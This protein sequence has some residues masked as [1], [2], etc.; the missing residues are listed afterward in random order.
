MAE[1]GVDVKREMELMSWMFQEKFRTDPYR[2]VIA[3]FPWGQKGTPL[4]R[5]EGPR[6]WQCDELKRLA[7]YIKR[8][9]VDEG[10]QRYVLSVSSGR[11]SG[12]SAFIGMITWWFRT[13]VF[14]GTCIVTANTEAQLRTRTFPEILKWNSLAIN[15]NWWDTTALSIRP[16]G[17]YADAL[18]RDLG[19]DAGY[20]YT[21]GQLWSEENP[22]AFAG[23]HSMSGTMLIFDEASNIAD[24]IWTVSEGFFTEPI[25]HRYWLVFGNMRRNSGKFYDTHYGIERK[26]WNKRIIDSRSV[27]G[28]DAKVYNDI[29]EK[30][31][32]Q[33]SDEA[34]VEVYGLPPK[35]KSDSIIPRHFVEAAAKRDVEL[36]AAAP[37]I[38]GLDPAVDG[39]RDRRIMVERQGN[40]LVWYKNYPPMEPMALCQA[41]RSDYDSAQNKPVAIF[42]EGLGIGA[43]Y[44]SR[45]KQLGLP[46]FK[47][48]ITSRENISPAYFNLRTELIYKV[49]DWLSKGNT[50][51]PND[52]E[53]KRDFTIPRV[54]YQKQ[55]GL[56][57]A[58]SKD[59]IRKRGER[60]YDILEAFMMTFAR[61]NLVDGQMRRFKSATDKIQSRVVRCA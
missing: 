13:F 34:R 52:E 21:Q 26:F 12:K 18:K 14:G 38:W 27:E 33:D 46:V 4:E 20:Y 16:A 29:I 60:S 7:L 32:D 51:I 58:E 22:D 57:I 50:R 28:V 39:M 25:Q 44:Y 23:A 54:D 47:V 61:E 6:K 8:N 10:F 35:G 17:W 59:S 49:R 2:A 9:G 55:S 42:V 3:C 37:I 36:E 19:I 48:Q 41:I 43:I 15:A 53:L 1:K 24:P 30:S 11:G 40:E 56:L 45:L 5:F 31:G